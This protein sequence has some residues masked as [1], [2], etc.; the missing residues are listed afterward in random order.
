MYIENSMRIGKTNDGKFII[1]YDV[2]VKK[3]KGDKENVYPLTRERNIVATDIEDLL[4]K[5]RGIAE[6]M[7]AP[8]S[9]EEEYNLAFEEKG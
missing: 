7:K 1:S 3:K 2:K 4:T 8:G 6:K 9:E 5:V